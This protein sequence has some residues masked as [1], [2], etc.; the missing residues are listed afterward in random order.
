MPRLHP[1]SA[2]KCLSHA[3]SCLPELACGTDLGSSCCD[4]GPACFGTD[5]YGTPLK[6]VEGACAVAFAAHPLVMVRPSKCALITSDE[7]LID[8]LC[9]ISRKLHF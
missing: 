3:L 5:G 1:P 4:D 9:S 6:C 7:L 2:G 8:L